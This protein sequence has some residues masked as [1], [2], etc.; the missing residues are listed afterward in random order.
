MAD[1][2]DPELN[3]SQ[4]QS[5]NNIKPEGM[6]A[7]RTSYQNALAGYREEVLH[8]SNTNGRR[9]LITS[10]RQTIRQCPFQ[11]ITSDMRALC[12][13]LEALIAADEAKPPVG[14]PQ[15]Q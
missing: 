4:Q 15:N 12:L 2:P 6:E 5:H 7:A 11:D 1:T 3:W 9:R 14:K 10:I 8:E 13:D